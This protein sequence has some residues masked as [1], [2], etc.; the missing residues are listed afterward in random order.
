MKKKPELLFTKEFLRQLKQLEKQTQIRIIK[1]LKIL[2]E[3]PY[4]GKPLV[5]RLHGLLS[6]R[7]GDYRIIYQIAENKILIRTVGHRKKVY[8][9]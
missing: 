2:E 1:E 6:L 3:K 5:G 9:K 8:E 7:V 4:T